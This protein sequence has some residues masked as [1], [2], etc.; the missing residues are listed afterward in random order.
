M[1][2]TASP[3]SPGQTSGQVVGVLTMSMRFAHFI[4]VVEYTHYAD[5][6]QS[7]HEW[8]EYFNQGESR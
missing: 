4:K 1:S 8:N 3:L 5:G 6:T 2:P 7:R